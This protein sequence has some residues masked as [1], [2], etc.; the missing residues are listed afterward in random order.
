MKVTITD[1]L[2]WKETI[3]FFE[4]Q[5]KNSAL[6]VLLNMNKKG[7]AKMYKLLKGA[8]TH[9]LDNIVSTWSKNTVRNLCNHDLST[10]F[11]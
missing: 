8:N 1:Y 2:F 5:P 4:P 9:L 10:S 11:N 7:C 3:D 6:N